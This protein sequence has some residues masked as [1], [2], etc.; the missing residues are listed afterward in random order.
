MN[1]LKAVE[2]TLEG[3]LAGERL[4]QGAVTPDCDRGLAFVMMT[5]VYKADGVLDPLNRDTI[6]Q[7]DFGLRTNVNMLQRGKGTGNIFNA[8]IEFDFG[9]NQHA[10]V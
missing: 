10:P 8:A 5:E 6:D 3:K 9:R 2:L 1:F 7:F 4:L